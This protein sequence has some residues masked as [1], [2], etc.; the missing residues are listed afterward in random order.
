MEKITVLVVDDNRSIRDLYKEILEFLGA[1]VFTAENA[2]DAINI[3][4][5]K[6]ADDVDLIISDLQ[7]PNRNGLELLVDVRHHNDDE[8]RQIPFVLVSS[9]MDKKISQQA[10]KLGATE[11]A[12]KPIGIDGFKRFLSLVSI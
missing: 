4:D 2:Y 1:I 7:M 10:K 5:V 11:T 3:L 8:I 9:I 12:Q 6:D